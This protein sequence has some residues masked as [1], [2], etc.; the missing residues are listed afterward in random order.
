MPYNRPMFRRL[1]LS[2]LLMPAAALGAGA[3]QPVPATTAAQM[4]PPAP[5]ALCET[6]ITDAESHQTLPARV[7]QAIALRESGR[8]DPATGRVRPWPW[9]INYQG[10]GRFY[11]TREQAIAAV[12]DIQASGG[13]SIDVGCMQVNLM[14]HP[15]AFASLEAAFDPTTNAAYAGRFLRTLY[16]ESGDWGVAIASYHSKTPGV[17]DL[18]RDQV[19][20][21]WNTVD[22]SVL[23]HLNHM[24]SSL[25]PAF[26]MVIYPTTDAQLVQAW[27]T[28]PVTPPPRSPAYPRYGGAYRS[29]QP[30]NVVYGDFNRRPV[31]KQRSKPIDMRVTYGLAI[32][33]G[34]LIS[35]KG[36]ATVT[37]TKPARA[38]ATAETGP[39]QRV[40]VTR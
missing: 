22:P 33:T 17:G 28:V 13:Q 18:Y 26:P 32:P 1:A 24:P 39:G 27:R 36:V 25:T 8:V 30:A 20:A 35:P 2:L 34:A 31:S 12:R 3:R 40:V 38:T 23:A 14:H 4:A 6:A 9:T 16:A 19:L 15:D 5:A 21:S 7:L 10:M 11:D 37:P 29:F